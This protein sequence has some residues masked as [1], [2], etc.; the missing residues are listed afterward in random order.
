MM[1]LPEAPVG[2]LPSGGGTQNLASLV[3]EGWATNG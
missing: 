2:L 3:G 1:A